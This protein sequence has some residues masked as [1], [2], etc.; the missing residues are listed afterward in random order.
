[1]KI[2]AEIPVRLGS[3]R[4]PKKYTPDLKTDGYAVEACRESTLVDEV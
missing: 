3:K 2:V 1:M 4:V